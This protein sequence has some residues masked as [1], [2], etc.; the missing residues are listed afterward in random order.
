LHPTEIFTMP[1]AST[2]TRVHLVSLG[3]A[4][5]QIDSEVMLGRLQES[6]AAVVDDPAAADVIVVNTCSFIESAANESIDTILELAEHKAKGSCRRLVVA[7][8]LPER[9]REAILEAIPEVDVFLGTG[10]FDRIVAAVRGEVDSGRCLLPDPDTLPVSGAAAPRLHGGGAMAY[11]KIA[12]G[13]NR[14]CTYCV[15]PKLRGRQKSRTP[16]DIETEAR[17]LLAGGVREL[18]LV[19]QESTA[20]GRDLSPPVGLSDLLEVLA[21]LP[22]TR[23]P[24][25]I[26]FLYGHPQS[27]DDAVI[28]TVAAHPN[29]C[30]YFDLP[31]QHADPAVLKRMGRNYT[32]TDVRRLADRIRNC[33]PQAVLRT[34]VIVGFPGE[35]DRAFQDL[36][37]FIETVRFHHLGCFVY[38]DDKDLAAHRLSGRVPA[39][40][41]GERYHELMIRQQK[42]SRELNQAYRGRTLEVLVEENPEIGLYSGRTCFQAPE[43]DGVTYV[44]GLHLQTGTF[45]RVTITDALEYD[46]VGEAQ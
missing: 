37:G 9:H 15:I 27:L 6:G 18:V 12:E 10:A 38:S 24:F 4:R 11:L 1:K 33:L 35:T 14:H 30:P 21:G 40:L 22:A 36:L 16:A 43:V 20:Y 39:A 28:R 7:G 32:G 25:W 42:I 46:L 41:A 5:N 13:C 31:V 23:G 34:T 3:C 26:R 17:R 19:A 44:R 2:T 45:A 8:C 29:I